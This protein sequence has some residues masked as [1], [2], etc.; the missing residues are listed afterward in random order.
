M[1]NF[2]LYAFSIK[3]ILIANYNGKLDLTANEVK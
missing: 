2:K 3:Y 1:I